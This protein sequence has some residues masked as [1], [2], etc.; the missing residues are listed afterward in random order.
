MYGGIVVSDPNTGQQVASL[1]G[2]RTSAKPFAWTEDGK[3]I[4][5]PGVNNRLVLW[6]VERRLE[7]ALYRSQ[8]E[9]ATYAISHDAS[10]IVIGDIL[11]NLYFL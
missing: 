9:T 6:D 5:Y 1:E 8:A 10:R 4:A 2:E 11:G 3:L 7:I